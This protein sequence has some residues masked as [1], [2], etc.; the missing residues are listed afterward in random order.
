MDCKSSSGFCSCKKTS[1]LQ[2]GIHQAESFAKKVLVIG[3]VK[4]YHETAIHDEFDDLFDLRTMSCDGNKH[5]IRAACIGADYILHMRSFSSHSVK[6]L[7]EISGDKSRI[8]NVDGSV[9]KAREAL[10]ALYEKLRSQHGSP[11]K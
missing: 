9:S 10:A 4:A 1:P 6:K 11:A 5:T 2:V 3:L 8:I 7:I